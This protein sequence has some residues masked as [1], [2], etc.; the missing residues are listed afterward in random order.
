MG[1]VAVAC[2]TGNAHA[3]QGAGVPAQGDMPHA[4]CRYYMTND[5]AGAVA[6]A[7]IGTFLQNNN[8]AACGGH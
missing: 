6:V 8:Q 2:F 7:R 3:G 5:K 1:A 4:F